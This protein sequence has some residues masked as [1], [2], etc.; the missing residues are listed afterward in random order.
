M[1]EGNDKHHP[2]QDSGILSG[3]V[4]L[5][6][7]AAYEFAQ[8]PID[9]VSQFVGKLTGHD[10]KGPQII[11][12]PDHQ[13][14]W[15]FGGDLIGQV[16]QYVVASKALH[17]GLRQGGFLPSAA[18][19]SWLEAAT[20]G[21]AVDLLHPVDPKAGNYGW[22]KLRSAGVA[23]GTFAAMG[24]TN[25]WFYNRGTFGRAGRR[26]LGESI[27]AN[28][29]SG[30]FGGVAN[31]ELDSLSHGEPLPSL[32]RFGSSVACYTAFGAM[33]GAGEHAL[34]R[35]NLNLKPAEG[36][37]LRG[38]TS[39]EYV[40]HHLDPNNPIRSPILTWLAEN[41]PD[42]RPPGYAEFKAENLSRPATEMENLSLD[43]WAPE[44]RPR[45]LNELRKMAKTQLA[46]DSNIDAFISRMRAPE[47]EAYQP[48]GD[49]RRIRLHQRWEDA[50]ERL[51]QYVDSHQDLRA[52]PLATLMKDQAKLAQHPQLRV[53]FDEL[54]AAE[55][56]Y[57]QFAR[58]QLD[59][60]GIED[61][62]RARVDAMTREVGLPKLQHV[63]SKI[64]DTGGAY[65]MYESRYNIGERAIAG[66]TASAHETQLHELV[67]HEQGDRS[68]GF[69]DGS[70][71][72]ALAAQEHVA[73]ELRWLQEP[74]G[75]YE[76]LQRL[77]DPQRQTYSAVFGDGMA[78]NQRDVQYL[79]DY[80]RKG[81][82]Y[83]ATWHEAEIKAQFQ[84]LLEDALKRHR[85]AAFWNHINGYVG[86]PREL[87]AWSAGFLTNIR[88]RALGLPDTP[89][90][91]PRRPTLSVDKLPEVKAVEPD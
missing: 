78:K 29:F 31:S 22:E 60:S 2:P 40:M 12:K 73:K 51:T 34:F 44:D 1:V 56:T 4:D 15:T 26:T 38:P 83:P 36:T 14:A 90:W 18:P 70:N 82:V 80:Y 10:I 23:F 55:Q 21:T 65:N 13:N 16:A 47:F 5:L 37:N 46:D 58:A 88:A 41:R 54:A 74:N 9:G 11:P 45:V 8:T 17:T 79:I 7:S 71:F 72:N 84:E 59:A 67:H 52:Y 77:A 42:L 75:T 85:Q 63:E 61:A 32:N 57:K 81:E 35:V 28:S 68:L 89:G 19:I 69:N 66:G 50:T 53:L 62:L 3:P 33:F 86:Q 24:A 39:E 6:Q 91:E 48:E 27:A 25:E 43:A 87:Q 76:F 30:F 64:D 20:A 49:P